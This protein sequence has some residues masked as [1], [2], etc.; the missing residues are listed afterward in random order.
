[1]SKLINNS[2]E[3][4]DIIN[5]VFDPSEEQKV[6]SQNNPSSSNL[7]NNPFL[8]EVDEKQYIQNFSKL[9]N[10]SISKDIV[11][12]NSRESIITETEKNKKKFI[13]DFS[14]AIKIL[15]VNLIS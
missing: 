9:F 14:R 2:E 1:M 10:G 5:L 8:M 15:N 6:K 12:S 11:E 13:Q 3:I 7:D 4:I